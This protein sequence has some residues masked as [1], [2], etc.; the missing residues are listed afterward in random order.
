[1]IF[2]LLDP[3]WLELPI[4]DNLDLEGKASD[5]EIWKAIDICGCRPWV[6]NLPQKLDA[7]VTTLS[8]GQKQ[9]LAMVRAILQ[10]R[11]IGKRRVLSLLILASHEK[12]YSLS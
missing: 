1:V 7:I 6:E 11:R 5:S 12:A 10:K 4:R 2:L 3:L 8:R 9:L